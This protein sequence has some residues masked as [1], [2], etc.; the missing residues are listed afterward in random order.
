[1]EAL[2]SPKTVTLADYTTFKIGGECAHFFEVK[3]TDQL[4]Y[5]IFYANEK[6]LPFLILGGGS[7]IL[8]R[9]QGYNGVVI[10]LGMESF[11]I[12]DCILK[13]QSGA[14]MNSIVR[15]AVENGYS[16]IEWASGL[17][18]TVGGAVRGNAG[19]FGG[20]IS[21]N[22]I[23]V[24]YMDEKGVSRE[25]GKEKC[26]FGYRDSMFKHNRRHIILE[27]EFKLNKDKSPEELK[28]K[29][30]KCINYRNEKHPLNLPNAGSIFK[31][32]DDKKE[33]KQCMKINPNIKE[34]M[35]KWAGKVSSAYLIEDCNLKGVRIGGGRISEHH[36]NFIVNENNAS[37]DDIR[38]LI[39]VVIEK[40]REKYAI[41]LKPEI[42]IP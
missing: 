5:A 39:R 19:A 27:A 12:E 23:S 11:S 4:K 21:D 33:I 22:I 15:H 8:F 38:K 40:V 9:D 28:E 29:Y 41:T 30:E 31:N 36:A 13:T 1:M 37:C 24:V 25:A 34:F 6:S 14:R 42:Y 17:P 32:I 10:K 3:D 18:G 2:L 26:S 35:K 7:N 16:G 20:C